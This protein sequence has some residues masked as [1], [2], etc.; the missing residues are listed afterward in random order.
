MFFFPLYLLFCCYNL[1][2]YQSRT[3]EL[4]DEQCHVVNQITMLDLTGDKKKGDMASL[5][6]N[7]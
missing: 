1:L 2:N 7:L 3:K 5:L 4:S 6:E